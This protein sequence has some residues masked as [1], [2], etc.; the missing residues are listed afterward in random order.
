V[1]SGYGTAKSPQFEQSLRGVALITGPR[2]VISRRSRR[3]TIFKLF[4]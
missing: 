2:P 1:L 4:Q 3:I